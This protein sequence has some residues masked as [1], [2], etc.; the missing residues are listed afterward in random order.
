MIERRFVGDEPT[1]LL[2]AAADLIMRWWPEVHRCRCG[3][4]FL[5]RHG[6]QR[7]HDPS[8]AFRARWS[9]FLSRRPRDYHAEYERR[10]KRELGPNVR[11]QRREKHVAR[12]VS[13]GKGR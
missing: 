2:V 4:L 11:T 9:K 12:D 7:Y 6:R 8:C 13:K 1:V 5:S 10:K 3:V